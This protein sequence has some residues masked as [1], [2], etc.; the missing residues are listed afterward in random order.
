MSF[1]YTPRTDEEWQLLNLLPEGKYFFKTI[2]AEESKSK[3]GHPMLVLKNLVTKPNGQKK[4]IKD[5]L[6]ASDE[7]GY[8]I[9]HYCDAV[10]L[11]A[12]YSSGQFNASHCCGKTGFLEL[13]ISPANDKYD[14]SNTVKSYVSKNKVNLNQTAQ[15]PKEILDDNIPF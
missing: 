8:K 12:V 3:D 4:T 7:M 6:I 13:K 10:G 9:K 5:W 14:T 11:E 2:E 1:S 15:T